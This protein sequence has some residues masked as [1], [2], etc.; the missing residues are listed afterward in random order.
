MPPNARIA[1]R[2]PALQF[3]KESRWIKKERAARGKKDW[4]RI[5]PDGSGWASASSHFLGSLNIKSKA[6][7]SIGHA[8]KEESNSIT[9]S[10]RES[11]PFLAR[12]CHISLQFI[13]I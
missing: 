11:K 3:G 2:L 7:F 12:H 4:P 1:L 13:E 5:P 8:D 10:S 9:N 6:I